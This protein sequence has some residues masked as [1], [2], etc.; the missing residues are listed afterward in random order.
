MPNNISNLSAIIVTVA[1]FI[2]IGFDLRRSM[3]RI[4][5][6]RTVV[7]LSVFLWYLLEALYVPTELASVSTQNEY[8][9]GLVYTAVSVMVFLIA[10]HNTSVPLF[11]PLGRRLHFL[12]Q[13]RVLWSLLLGCMAIGFGGLL[14]FLEFNISAFFEGLTGMVARWG[15]T[16]VRGRYGNWRTILYELQLFLTAAIP[17]AVALAF[18]KHATAGRRLVAGL[19]LVWMSVRILTSGSRTPLLPVVLCVSAAIVWNAS[20][21]VRRWLIIGGVPCALIAGYILS[22]IIV[23]GRNEG[24]FDVKAGQETEYVGFEM[25][26]ELLFVVRANQEGRLERQ[27]GF[28]YVTQLVN[29]IPRAI[30]PDKPVADAGLI[31][32]RAYGAVDADGE[33]TMTISPGFLGEAVLN[34]GLVGILIVPLAAGVIVRA[35]DRLLPVATSSLPPFLIYA[36]GLGTIF[37]SGRSFNFSTFYGLL[38]LY[39]LLLAFE[40]LGL[41][42]VRVKRRVQ[43]RPALS[44]L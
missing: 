38:A 6:G 16:L 18:M 13:P 1:L 10:Y 14:L 40:Y 25:F 7:L 22:A 11:N 37:A 39:L 31:L 2:C 43:R 33:P 26:R 9:I 15:A 29:P 27:M 36:A 44:G 32:A 35:W 24:K 34:F 8:D 30:W 4:M 41:A 21:R 20:P 28:T 19:F 3:Y 42:G 23:M 12:N 5:T 17:L